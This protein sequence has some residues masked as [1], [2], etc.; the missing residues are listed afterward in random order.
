MKKKRA[1]NEP[2][3]SGQGQKNL[4]EHRTTLIERRKSGKKFPANFPVTRKVT[5][6]TFSGKRTPA[7]D[8]QSW[9]TQPTHRQTKKLG[10]RDKICK[11]EEER[12]KPATTMGL[13]RW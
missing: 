11:R 1:L 5:R 4:P 13:Q 6:G 8:R 3:S 10:D 2:S 7:G 9:P 12:E